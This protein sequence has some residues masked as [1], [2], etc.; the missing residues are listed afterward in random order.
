M[1]IFKMPI[2]KDV[3]ETEKEIEEIHWIISIGFEHQM[4]TNLILE[5]I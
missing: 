1:D 5:S 2:T 3:L 4:D